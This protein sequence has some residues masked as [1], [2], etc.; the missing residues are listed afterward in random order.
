MAHAGDVDSFDKLPILSRPS[1]QALV[2]GSSKVD[3]RLVVT[4]VQELLLGGLP[5]LNWIEQQMVGDRIKQRDGLLWLNLPQSDAIV[6]R[7]EQF[8]ARPVSPG[9]HLDIQGPNPCGPPPNLD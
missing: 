3:E 5:S 6:R 4:A 7:L 8:A 2:Q 9:M 1:R